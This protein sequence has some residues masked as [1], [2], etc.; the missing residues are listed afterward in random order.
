MTAAPTELHPG[1]AP[2]RGLFLLLAA[3]ALLVALGVGLLLVREGFHGS[4]GSNAVQG[5]GVAATQTRIV[6][7]F[8][9]VELRGSNVVTIRVG[10][11]Q[12]VVVHADENLLRR[13]TTNVKAGNL[14]VGNTTGSFTA[15]SPMSVEVGVPSLQALRISGSGTVTAIGIHTSR[16]SVSLPGSGVVQVA[17]TVSKLV[18]SLPGSGYAQLEQLVARDA[19]VT[20]GGSGY[21]ALN[22][23]QSLHAS[24]SGSGAVVY[25][26]NPVHV[27]TSITGV[28]TIVAQ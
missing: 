12:S 13:V 25:G 24:V 15:R 19:W 9:R 2:H 4:S 27:T 14:V 20:V 28:G 17:G 3:C 21:A 6:G 10:E 1:R 5:S 23:T 11:R 22:A 18:V 7:P 16:L 26:G 8:D